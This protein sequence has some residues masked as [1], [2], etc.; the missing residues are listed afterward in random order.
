MSAVPAA[1]PATYN[2]QVFDRPSL[3]LLPLECSQLAKELRTLAKSCLNPVP[4]YQCLSSAPHALDD[5]VIAVM[6]ETQGPQ[7][8]VAFVSAV[9]LHIPLG[10]NKNEGSTVLH[11]GLTCVV[12]GSKR[13]GIV[14]LLFFHLFGY[15]RAQ[16]EF[17]RGLWMTSVAEVTSSLGNIAEYA[18][19]VYPSP[20]CNAPSSTHVRIADAVSKKYRDAMLIAPDAVFDQER[21]VFR[22]ANPPG[23]CFRKDTEDPRYHHRDPRVNDYYRELLGRNEGNIVLQVGYL[24]W[25][26]LFGRVQEVGHVENFLKQRVRNLHSLEFLL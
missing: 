17:V 7:R 2:F 24:G 25:E 20:Q 9:Y 22:G 4:N 23:S 16:P 18:V 6:R 14:A 11:T 1:P 3:T 26:R 5:K 8:I 19:D 12:P 15:L 13:Q 21:F 10:E